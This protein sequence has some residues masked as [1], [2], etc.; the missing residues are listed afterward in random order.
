MA[1]PSPTPPALA[2]LTLGG[3]TV[4]L[5][6]GALVPGL[7]VVDQ[8][9]SFSFKSPIGALFPIRHF[10]TF[11]AL[12]Y[13][14]LPLL[15]V[16]G[17]ALTSKRRARAATSG[18]LFG[19]GVEMYLVVLPYMAQLLA[20]GLG[21]K[22]LLWLIS[23]VGACLVLTGSALLY[24]R[25]EDVEA[26]RALPRTGIPWPTVLVGLLGAAALLAAVVLPS[27]PD[28]NGGWV[29]LL[30]APGAAKWSALEPFGLAV[31]AIAAVA[32]AP[33]RSR[34][35]IGGV[36]SGL[37]VAGTISFLGTVIWTSAGGQSAHV[38]SVVG[39]IGAVGL[40]C[41]G[42][43]ALATS[44]GA[45]PLSAMQ[46]GAAPETLREM[47]G[48]D[49]SGNRESTRL[50]AA[51]AEL[52]ARF[53][54]RVVRDVLKDD[55]RAVAPSFGVNLGTVLRHCV[56]ARGRQGARNILLMALTLPLLLGLAHLSMAAGAVS[57][58]SAFALGCAAIFTESW[59]ARY[60]IAAR[61][62]NRHSYAPA[63]ATR[64][65]P[66]GADWRIRDVAQ[67]E[68]TNIVVY[69]GF[70]PFVGSGLNQGGWSFAVNI[71]RGREGMDGVRYKP[72]RF[73][74][75]DLQAAVAS[76]LLELGMDLTIS[77]RLYVDGE[78]VRDEPRIVPDRFHRPR[79]HVLPDEIAQL[80]EEGVGRRFNCVS[81]SGWEGELVYTLF[82]EFALSGASL[83]A[84]ATT[85]L[86]L[87]PTEDYRR[88]DNIE[89][90]PFIG[91]RLRAAGRALVSTVSVPLYAVRALREA[92]PTLTAWRRR[93]DGRRAI[94]SNPRY[95]YGAVRSVREEAQS[96]RYR[97]YFQFADRD[98]YGKIIDRE[99]FDAI[100]AFLAEHD[101]DTS[102]FDERQAAVLNFGVM[103][104]GGRLDAQSLAVGSRAQSMVTAQM[105]RLTSQGH[106]TSGG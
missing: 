70:S 54:R 63:A 55:Y 67:A 69:S 22:A 52:D 59:T 49:L 44:R 72:Q 64:Y 89:P 106:A 81:L 7:L 96:R 18:V 87:P 74:V 32:G 65:L 39:L 16:A 73:T 5:V 17:L 51:A 48:V 95:D 53:A 85:F 28:G 14:L 90:R 29:S 68:S 2:V 47:S 26:P 78:L 91:A 103:V 98:M 4:L 58:L 80:A 41:G 6:V 13:A 100:R 40:L 38:G 11:L 15:V 104:T 42:I 92:T 34:A 23:C 31:I 105:Q 1:R 12:V 84:D 50:L 101:I 76:H 83:F 20:A 43:I 10:N 25:A 75:E 79:S 77:D 37:G 102:D 33:G 60:R 71:A 24:S 57:V 56:A 35:T 82:L 19:F 36:L 8:S 3:G 27:Q 86:L 97:R 66:P 94:A 46:S 88:V 21:G 99:V 61:S 62:L 93:V 45:A 9:G 30:G